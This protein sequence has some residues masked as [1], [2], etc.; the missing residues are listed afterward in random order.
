MVGLSFSYFELF[1]LGSFG[2]FV[3]IS[4]IKETE[5]PI[6]MLK[7]KS[8]EKFKERKVSK[9]ITPSNTLIFLI[10]T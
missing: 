3:R 4:T 9:N 8:K 5:N 1:L 10:C 7:N 6:Q 2:S